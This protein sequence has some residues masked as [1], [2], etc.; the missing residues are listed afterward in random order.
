MYNIHILLSGW[1]LLIN[2]FWVFHWYLSIKKYT[3]SLHILQE[4]IP[5]GLVCVGRRIKHAFNL[6]V[7]KRMM[8][9]ETEMETI[10]MDSI[11]K[12]FDRDCWEEML[13]LL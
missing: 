3:L 10:I 5:I 11:F 6:Y 8:Q 9:F 12:W 1:Q 2:I 4:L 13:G 7:R